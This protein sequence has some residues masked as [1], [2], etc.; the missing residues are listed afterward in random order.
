MDWYE[1]AVDRDPLENPMDLPGLPVV[2][3]ETS[4]EILR[5]AQKILATKLLNTTDASSSGNVDQA[6]K[7]LESAAE[8][9]D[10]QA[11]FHL[12]LLYCDAQIAD[13][14]YS[15]ARKWF[16]EAAASNYPPAYVNLG[17]M[18]ENGFGV[19]RNYLK[20]KENYLKAVDS[21]DP[22][23]QYRLGLLYLY[24]GEGVPSDEV[25]AYHWIKAAADAG[26]PEAVA[27]L[28]EWE[29]EMNDSNSGLSPSAMQ[30]WRIIDGME[31]VNDPGDTE[32]ELETA[33]S[34]SNGFSIVS[35]LKY[36]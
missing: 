29:K 14:D 26:A 12:G 15:Q 20:A 13:T 24:G 19:E 11:Q 21:G 36:L 23:G 3:R 18:Y 10:P 1:K 17:W 33:N 27:K 16:Q 25:K 9:K 32:N 35:V 4:W 7:L 8:T 5:H 30:A 2:T 22:L 6:R 34:S 28:S 31:E